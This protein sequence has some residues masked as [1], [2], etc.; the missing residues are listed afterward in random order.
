MQ[1]IFTIYRTKYFTMKISYWPN[2]IALNGKQPYDAVLQSISKTDEL[3]KEDWDADAAIIWSVLWNGRM[4]SN[5]AVWNHYRTRNRPVIVVEVGNLIRNTTWKLSA[6]GIG[7]TALWPDVH[8]RNRSEKLGIELKPEYN[9][10]ENILICLQHTKSEQWR[11]MPNIYD[12][13]DEKISLIQSVSDR[14]IVIRPHPRD[15][16]NLVKLKGATVVKPKYTNGDDTDFLQELKN[17]HLVVCHNSNPGVQSVINGVRVRCGEDCLA[18]DVS[19]GDFNNM[20]NP[21]LDREKWFEKILHTEWTIKELESGIPWQGL[22]KT[23][24]R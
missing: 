7:R 2:S 19:I 9:H 6:N 13:L 4:K 11:N 21:L 22:R 12:W 20:E 17:T 16:I 10:G 15:P 1:F 24:N 3:S 5:Q 8:D 14:P 23:F 18:A